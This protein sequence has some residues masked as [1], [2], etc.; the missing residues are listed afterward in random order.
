V[1]EGALLN[2]VK[3]RGVMFRRC[4]FGATV[5]VDL[6]LADVFELASTEHSLPSAVTISTLRESHGRISV[7]FL[8]HCGFGV[9]ELA[10]SALYNQHLTLDEIADAVNTIQMVRG[11]SPVQIKGVFISYASSDAEFTEC[12]R[13]EL[14][15]HGLVCFLDTHDLLAGR[16]ETQLT[17][18]I[19]LQSVFILVLSERSIASDWVQWEVSKAREEERVRH[20]DML[21]PVALDDSWKKAQWPGPLRFQIE[22]YNILDFSSWKDNSAFAIQ[23]K[24][25]FQGLQLYYRSRDAGSA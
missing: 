10:F 7:D 17:R 6:N 3:V 5:L 25:L 9:G 20:Q 22:Q 14:E 21:C 2:R 15:K 8:S 19:G 23:F 4:R 24:K 18:A 12:L 11:E 13:R 1:L 16:I